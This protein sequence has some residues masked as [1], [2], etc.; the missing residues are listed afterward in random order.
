M[1]DFLIKYEAILNGKVIKFNY[2]GGAIPFFRAVFDAV[3]FDEGDYILIRAAVMKRYSNAECFR[4]SCGLD[5]NRIKVEINFYCP[6][7]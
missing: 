6:E 2:C 7:I 4:F 3:A 5:G 1:E